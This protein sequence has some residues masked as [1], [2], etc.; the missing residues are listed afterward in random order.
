MPRESLLGLCDTW[1][2]KRPSS[3]HRLEKQELGERTREKQDSADKRLHKGPTS[4][5]ALSSV[6]GCGR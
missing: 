4:A 6:S 5:H 2:A 3:S 1:A